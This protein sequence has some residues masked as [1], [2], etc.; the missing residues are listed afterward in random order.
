[1]DHLEGL[2]KRTKEV[3]R[4]VGGMLN[5]LLEWSRRR[6]KP[7]G[8]RRDL[9]RLGITAEEFPEPPG[10][11]EIEA[12]VDRG[13]AGAPDFSLRGGPLLDA[14]ISLNPTYAPS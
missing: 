10:L 9:R 1:M 12:E 11:I 2:E 4:L 5:D 7:A 8:F 13:L 3:Y 14:F 6:H